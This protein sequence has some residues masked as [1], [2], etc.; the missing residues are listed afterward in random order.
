M[1]DGMPSSTEQSLQLVRLLYH[2]NLTVI[3]DDQELDAF[4]A[5][6][7]FHPHQ[8]M[9]SADALRQLFRMLGEEQ[10]LLLTDAF[11]VRAALFYIDGIPAIFGPFTSVLLTERDARNLLRR[12]PLS[13]VRER[14]LLRYANSY[15]CLPET[16]VTHIIT[17]LMQVVYSGGQDLE[18]VKVS[19]QE[20]PEPGS[21]EKLAGQREDYTRL[22]EKRYSYERAFIQS[23]IE[24]NA[25]NALRNLHSMQMD[26]AY[27]KR[28]GTTMEN[29]RVGA[30]IVRTTT[31]LAAL[32]AGLPSV[33]SDKISTENTVAV[34]RA[35]RIDE[36]F[37]AQEK[38]VREFCKAVWTIRSRPHSALVQS[39][40]YCIEKEY[41]EDITV[42][43]LAGDLDVSVNHLINVF[44]KEMQV[45]PNVYLRKY[46][47]EQAARIL[48]TTD[49]PVQDVASRVGI[50]DANY[51]IKLFKAQFGETPNAYRKKHR[52]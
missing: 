4:V 10:L 24:G 28:I 25:G 37:R 3:R 44:K 15:P 42:Q 41:A 36:I 13:G 23:I 19:Y 30:A 32:Q 34:I 2:V 8:H 5:R 26:V 50:A 47:M 18:I 45:T 22:L 1:P 29:E 49:L 21:E 48:A 38:M 51:M 16:A 14:E 43:S 33:I 39:A 52:V 17:S 31:R 6:C 11:M 9:L 20:A 35:S 46:R 27:L 12:H 40:L 7:R